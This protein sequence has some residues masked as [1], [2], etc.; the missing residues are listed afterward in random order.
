MYYTSLHGTTKIK[1]D[2]LKNNTEAIS[3]K[4]PS[5]PFIRL[6]VVV[7]SIVN[8]GLCALLAKRMEEPYS[9]QWALPGDSLRIDIDQTLYDGAQR[10]MQ[11]RLGI[12]PACLEQLCAVGGAKRDPHAPWALSVVYLALVPAESVQVSAGKRIEVLEWREVE[13]AIVEPLA[14]DHAELIGRA[15]IN[16]REQVEGMVMPRG[17]L[18]DNFTLSELQITCEQVIGRPLDKSSFRRKLSDRKLVEP[19]EGA[20]RGGSFRPAQ[21][22]RLK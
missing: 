4:N 11:E 13:Q 12:G 6:E 8:N 10:V 21:L 19:V 1:V 22:F 18:E 7:F 16:L 20:M 17:L 9:G 14:F 2:Q 5:M 15:V 3:I